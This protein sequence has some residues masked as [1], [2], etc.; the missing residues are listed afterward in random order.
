M[1]RLFET[2]DSDVAKWSRTK[3]DVGGFEGRDRLDDRRLHDARWNGWP[4]P[5]RRDFHQGLGVRLGI[6]DSTPHWEVKT[7]NC[8]DLAEWPVRLSLHDPVDWLELVVL[9]FP[10]G[11]ECPVAGIVGSDDQ[12]PL[13]GDI[14]DFDKPRIVGNVASRRQTDREFLGPATRRRQDRPL[15]V[16]ESETHTGHHLANNGHRLDVVVLGWIDHRPASVSAVIEVSNTV[17]VGSV[18]SKT[19][20]PSVLGSGSW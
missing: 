14:V 11:A 1:Q 20:P 17:P 4:S 15:E 16:H 2:D 3:W 5:L 8:P 19:H 9:D 12:A 13:R 6:G 18:A 10:F 7:A